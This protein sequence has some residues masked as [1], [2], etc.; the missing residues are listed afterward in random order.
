MGW[1]VSPKPRP[2][3]P[4]GKTQ[5]PLYRRLG[6][7]H[8]LSGQVK[9]LVPTGIR[10]R[11]VQPVVSRYNDWATGPTIYIYVYVCVCVCGVCVCVC[12]YLYISDLLDWRSLLH[13]FRHRP[14]TDHNLHLLLIL[15]AALHSL[16]FKMTTK[17]LTLNCNL[18]TNC[19]TF[20]PSELNLNN[21]AHLTFRGPCIV[22]YSYN[23]ASEMHQFSNLFW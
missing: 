10:S 12:V 19:H 14:P 22:I 2:S 7:P 23:K 17:T 1:R 13:P 20:H 3:L 11:T 8:G 16:L 15:V 4:P 18:Q 9:N 21:V 6:G 5:C